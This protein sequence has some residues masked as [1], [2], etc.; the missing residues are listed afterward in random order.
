M[1]K[2]GAAI[3]GAILNENGNT[4]PP[5]NFLSCRNARVGPVCLFCRNARVGP[6]AVDLEQEDSTWE[7]HN[8]P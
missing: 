7:G 5:C 3:N 4:T 2:E 6:G 8:G 1:R